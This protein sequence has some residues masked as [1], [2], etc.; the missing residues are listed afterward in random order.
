M[1]I[2]PTHVGKWIIY[3]IYGAYGYKDN[4]GYSSYFHKTRLHEAGNFSVFAMLFKNEFQLDFDVQ[5]T[6]KYHFQC[7]LNDTSLNQENSTK[8]RYN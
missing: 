7:Q 2:N 5:N 1:N 8:I 6:S 3:A 4:D